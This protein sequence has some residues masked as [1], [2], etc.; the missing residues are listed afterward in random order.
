MGPKEEIVGEP[1]P[2]TLPEAMKVGRV[3]PVVEIV[4]FIAGAVRVLLVR[5]SA[6]A[7]PISVS[8]RSGKVK[9][10]VA[11]GDQLSTPRLVVPKVI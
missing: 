4:P 6:V 5:V 7:R 3:R 10:R 9:V 1:D 8:V 2:T 11:D